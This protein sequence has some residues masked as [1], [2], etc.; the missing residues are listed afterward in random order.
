MNEEL[1]ILRLENFVSLD[2]NSR[3]ILLFGA[4]NKLIEAVNEINNPLKDPAAY[5]I[6]REKDSIIARHIGEKNKLEQALNMALD[7]LK[8]VSMLNLTGLEFVDEEIEQINK[9]IGEQH[10]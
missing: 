7:T 6:M 10:E 8:E 1:K 5:R 4:I 9:L 2:T 3:F